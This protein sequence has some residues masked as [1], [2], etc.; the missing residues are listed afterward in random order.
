MPASWSHAR[1]TLQTNK[2]LLVVV[3]LR[4]VHIAR[5]QNSL[6][7]KTNWIYFFDKEL[8]KDRPGCIAT[9][10]DCLNAAGFTTR[11][12]ASSSLCFACMQP[13]HIE[14]NLRMCG[15][16]AL[17]GYRR[18]ENRVLFVGTCEPHRAT[19]K[20]PFC[21]DFAAI[22]CGE[23][24][25]GGFPHGHPNVKDLVIRLTWKCTDPS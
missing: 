19:P 15:C 10:I 2:R 13:E 20:K 8:L 22:V 3:G 23:S 16:V 18:A 4:S 12:I 1:T 25:L 21:L 6:M 7:S 11:L 24:H 9:L 5:L 17:C 14:Q